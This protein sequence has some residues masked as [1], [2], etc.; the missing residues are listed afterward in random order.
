MVRVRFSS[1]HYLCY[2]V[3]ARYFKMLSHHPSRF[4]CATG[5]IIG[6]AFTIP[7]AVAFD[8][9]TTR[10]NLGPLTT[11][12]TAASSCTNYGIVGQNPGGYQGQGCN[13]GHL[14]DTSACWPS[15]TATGPPDAGP[16]VGWGF[17][18]PGLVC[19]TGYTTACSAYGSDAAVP[20][21][22]APST[23]SFSFNFP[24]T[25][26]ETALGCCPTGFSCVK[27]LGGVQTC[28]QKA[29]STSFLVGTCSGNTLTDFF[30]R[31][32][33]ETL[34]AT[35]AST[36]SVYT[37]STVSLWAPLFQLNVQPSDVGL[38]MN[39]KAGSGGAAVTTILSTTNTPTSSPTDS[40]V[41]TG[42]SPASTAAIAVPVSLAGL[43]LLFGIIA[44]I[45]RR[46]RR[47]LRR[48]SLPRDPQQPNSELPEGGAGGAA[49]GRW[50]KRRHEIDSTARGQS[51]VK[52]ELQGP[53][54][55][56]AWYNKA[57][58]ELPRSPARAE[59]P[60]PE[61]KPK[62]ASR[63]GEEGMFELPAK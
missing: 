53:G 13:D 22:F 55:A 3:H 28:L 41:S 35:G 44:F 25:G 6:L 14:Y 23:P 33:P 39:D 20:T 37:T 2:T 58:P 52:T 46:R 16:L 56:P 27:Y 21:T 26:Q 30:Y 10:N 1:K 29:A 38:P 59:A 49:G 4:R 60:G 31:T 40:P 57:M 18:S 5:L 24:L 42:L 63:L 7:F 17:Y 8:P 62:T 15:A 51:M 12:F 9:P 43:A 47:I 34:Q 32:A 36:W 19:P 54:A 61:P 50:H 45:W 11:T 48:G